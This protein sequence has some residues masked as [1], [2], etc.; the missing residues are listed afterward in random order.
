M[1]SRNG[2]PTL[3][4]TP[5]SRVWRAKQ[6]IQLESGGKHGAG[7]CLRAARK[8]K[9]TAYRWNPPGKARVFQFEQG[10]NR[11]KPTSKPVGARA[12]TDV[13]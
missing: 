1:C 5:P 12:F 11:C 10:A 4:A 13:T 8:V 6:G 9:A 3:G 7:V 2:A